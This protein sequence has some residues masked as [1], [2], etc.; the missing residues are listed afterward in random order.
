MATPSQVVAQPATPPAAL[1]PHPPKT[2]EYFPISLFGAPM[3]LATPDIGI[4]IVT[5]DGED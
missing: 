3:A 5:A 2:P 1:A 4:G